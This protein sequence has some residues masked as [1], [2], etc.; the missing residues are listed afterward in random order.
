MKS[1]IYDIDDSV[2]IVRTDTMHNGARYAV[3]HKQKL[4][5]T[6]T[7]VSPVGEYDSYEVALAKAEFYTD[8]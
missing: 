4:T 6:L 8:D 2:C 1:K 7:H 5:D 3:M